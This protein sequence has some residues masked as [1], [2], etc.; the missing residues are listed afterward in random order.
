M[1]YPFRMPAALFAGVGALEHLGPEAKRL[2]DRAILLTDK[3]LMQVGAVEPVLAKLKEAG[4]AVTIFDEV[5]QEPSI[6]NCERAAEV[7]RES[8]AKFIVAV[9]GGSVLDVA[10]GCSILVTNGGRISDYFGIEKV[11]L[12]GMPWIGLPTTSGTGSEVTPIAIFTDRS[13]QLKIGVVSNHLFAAVAIVD[14]VLTLTAPPSVTAA[15]GMDALTH[16]IEAF[17]SPKAT[18][19]TDLYA[20]EAIRLISR[21]LRTAVWAGKDLQARTDM[22][23]GSLFAGLSFA[24]AGVGA[25]H[26]LAYPLGG[27]FGIP[28]GVANSLLL[29]HV[30]AF[31]MV[32]NIHKFARIAE[33]LGEN[34]AGLSVRAAAEAAVQSVRTLSLDVGIPQ[35]LRDVNVPESALDG[36]AEAAMKVTRLLDNNPRKVTL[37]DARAL[38]Q[39]AY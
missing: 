20:L 1:V 18:L 11:P 36:L 6:E 35:R 15:T 26:A 32:S 30:M 38:Y 2:G 17:T 7:V 14:P 16:A 21:S 13:Q 19:H 39:A 22:A 31:N 9:G 8:G 24:N 37:Q 4:V 12:P 3:V 33:A 27:Q 25:V 10:K 23:M 29:P 34:V 28:H 5:E